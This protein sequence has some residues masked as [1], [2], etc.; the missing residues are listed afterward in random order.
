[1]SMHNDKSLIPF[2]LY[3]VCRFNEI[4]RAI[5][6]SNFGKVLVIPA[7]FWGYN[8]MYVWLTAIFVCASNVQAFRGKLLFLKII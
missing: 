7:V 2:S 6:L 8:E 5:L 1:M 3:F 4:V